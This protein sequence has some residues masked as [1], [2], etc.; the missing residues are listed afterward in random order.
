MPFCQGDVRLQG[1]TPGVDLQNALTPDA[2]GQIDR[3]L[4]V[5]A[6]RAQQG[7][8]KHV[9]PVC[10]RQNDDG[11][12]PVE[13][14]HLNQQLVERLLALVVAAIM[15]QPRL[16]PMASISSMKIRHGDAAFALANRSRTREAPTPTI[17][18]T[19]SDPFTEKKG[20]VRLARHR[21]RQ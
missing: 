8:I 15:P 5:E 18:S 2:V 19:N 7:R 11:H 4:P 21:P 14:I 9:G 1:N 20:H 12:G 17:I 6:P 10:R 3:D 13:A 16:R